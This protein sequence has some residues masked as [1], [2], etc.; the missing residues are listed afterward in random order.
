MYRPRGFTLI[1]LLVVISIVAL[2]IALLM[3]AIKRARETARQAVC[4]SNMHQMLIGLHG[5]A[6]DNR[7]FFPFGHGGSNAISTFQM[8]SPWARDGVTRWGH[9]E[10]G[11]V[12]ARNGST[13]GWTGMGRLFQ[14]EHLT[15]PKGVYC[16]SQRWQ[17][18]TYPFGWEESLW[19]GYKVSSY[20]YRMFGQWEGNPISEDELREMHAHRPEDDG[21]IALVSDIFHLGHSSWGPS[22][23]LLWAHDTP[24]PGLSR[25]YS[26]GHAAFIVDERVFRYATAFTNIGFSD[27]YAFLFWQYLDGDPS[28]VETILNLP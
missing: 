20:H 28:A 17:H 12:T 23:G 18:F 4:I 25:G 5:Y 9:Y 22:D 14:F 3:P 16:P 19:A 2:L 27:F 10:G 8:T 6:A 15:D 13:V 1:E 26:D 7:G 24:N 21:P 11:S